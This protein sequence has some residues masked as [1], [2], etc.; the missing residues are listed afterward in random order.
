MIIY[1]EV[2]ALVGSIH[3]WLML[4]HLHD[5]EKDGHE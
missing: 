5:M 4:F 1:R 2:T 3:T